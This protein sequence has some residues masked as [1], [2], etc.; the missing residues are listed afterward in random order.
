[1]DVYPVVAVVQLSDSPSRRT[2]HSGAVTLVHHHERVI[3]FREVAD[4]VHR[5]DITVHR[6]YAVGHYDTEALCLGFL[7]TALELC[8]IGIGITITHCLTKT[9][10]VDYGCVI[11]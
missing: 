11:Q 6:E 3:F 1:M 4:F 8:H 2:Y 7:K 9:Y 10:A 5:G